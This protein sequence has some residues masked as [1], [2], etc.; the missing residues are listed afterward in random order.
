MTWD[1][2]KA[3]LGDREKALPGVYGMALT[4][5]D[6]PVF[7]VLEVGSG[8]GIFSRSVLEGSLVKLTTIDKR[9]I[10]EEFCLRTEGFGDRVERI[11]GD[12]RMVLPELKLASKEYDLAMVDGSHLYHDCLN[13]LQLVWDML[14]PGGSLLI[15]DVLH[16]HNFDDDY[17]VARALWDFMTGAQ[18]EEF[19]F[20]KVGSGGVGCNKKNNMSVVCKKC[21]VYI[22]WIKTENGK[23]MPVDPELKT[24][25]T[26]EGKTVRGYITH[27]STCPN[28]NEFKK[29]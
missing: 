13:D 24:I 9:D 6:R 1:N 2:F 28:V 16:P 21:G 23:L 27:W 17:G 22:E 26:K 5:C 10:L 12:S 4:E 11:V 29:K 20:M 25:V 8:W 7:D 3:G 14:R 19:R 15:D 18:I